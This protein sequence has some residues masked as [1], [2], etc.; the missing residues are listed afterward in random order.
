[1][2]GC[3]S[4]LGDPGGTLE[5]EGVVDEIP[6]IISGEPIALG[7]SR[8]GLVDTPGDADGYSVDLVA[9]QSYIFT[10]T[11]TGASPLEDPLLELYF[12]GRKVAMDDDA[13]PGHSAMM[14]FTAPET[15]TY[16][17]SARAW[18]PDEGPT[19]TGEYTLAAALGPPQ[20]S[21]DALDLGF[22]VPTTD[23]SVYFAASGQTHDGTMAQRS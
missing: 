18:E 1:L 15:G 21:L 20:N 2:V 19:L 17:V 3:T 22:A 5:S 4:A 14:R 9:G 7:S 13:G 10:L 11:G 8:R 12:N 16:Y 23:I 6:P